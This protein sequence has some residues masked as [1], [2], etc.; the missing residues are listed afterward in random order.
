MSNRIVRC[1]AF[2]GPE[3]V[4]SG[5]PE[6]V[7]FALE[8]LARRDPTIAPR[9]FDDATAW[10]IHLDQLKARAP[11]RRKLGVVAREVTLLPH[12]WDWLNNQPG[13]AS[14][15]LRRLIDE[16]RHADPVT[17][18]VRLARAAAYRFIT[19]MAGDQPGYGEATKALFASDAARYHALIA[20]W[21]ADVRFYAAILAVDA[22]EE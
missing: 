10:P 18:R 16:A 6:D 8:K 4:A 1:T 17:D 12:H 20:G 11:G 9:I 2:I 7:A 14:V 13:G 22:F 15:A 3:I 19:A 5:S 21:P